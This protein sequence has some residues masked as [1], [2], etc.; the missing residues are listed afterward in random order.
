MYVPVGIRFGGSELSLAVLWGPGTKF[1][2]VPG[3][4]NHC[5]NFSEIQ[6]SATNNRQMLNNACTGQRL[7]SKQNGRNDTIQRNYHG[8]SKQSLAI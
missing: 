6:S 3:H 8:E 5:E 4:F 2:G 7:G 1:W